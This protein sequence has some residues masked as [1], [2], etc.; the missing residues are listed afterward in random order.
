[1]HFVCRKGVVYLSG[2]LPSEA[3]HQILLDTLTDVLGFKEI[4]D[5][6]D[7]EELLWQSDQ[8]ARE[9]APEET[10]RWKDSPG[11]EDIFE[12]NEEGTEFIAPA[13]PIPEEQ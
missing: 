6:L 5:H 4:V 13:K 9:L 3:E 11:S 10:A 2:K 8:R 1:M 12:T 7:I